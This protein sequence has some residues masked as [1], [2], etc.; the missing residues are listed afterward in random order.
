MNIQK[1]KD[2]LL[3]CKFGPFIADTSKVFSTGVEICLHQFC[4]V[5]DMLAVEKI[6]NERC[7]HVDID[8]SRIHKK[9]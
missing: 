1:L 9:A 4:C 3:I 7:S 2:Q 5:S 8:R 6:G